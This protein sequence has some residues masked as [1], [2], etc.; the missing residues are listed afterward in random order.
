MSI[1]HRVMTAIA[2]MVGLPPG[3]PFN[4]VAALEQVATAISRIHHMMKA[5]EGDREM[6]R[7]L[8]CAVAW[9]LGQR[10]Q[11]DDANF[12]LLDWPPEMEP[13]KPRVV[14]PA[15]GLVQLH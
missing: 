8:A 15:K 9:D 4:A 10:G 13:E 5:L 14:E 7:L 12:V 6:M 2:K 1:D 3:V 11:L